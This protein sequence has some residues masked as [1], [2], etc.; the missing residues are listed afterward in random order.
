MSVPADTAGSFHKHGKTAADKNMALN[1][2][3]KI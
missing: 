2:I 1:N 3:I